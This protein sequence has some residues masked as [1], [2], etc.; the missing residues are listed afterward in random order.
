MVYVG[1][2]VARRP[3]LTQIEKSFNAWYAAA[4]ELSIG[5]ICACA[6][7]LKKKAVHYGQF[8]RSLRSSRT[9]SGPAAS[10]QPTPK[11][12]RAGRLSGKLSSAKDETDSEGTKISSGTVELYTLSR[13]QD[14]SSQARLTATD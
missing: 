11:P 1:I 7:A 9:A 14:S 6:P 5:I 4:L 8:L 3:V 10:K 2:T 12:A 13:E